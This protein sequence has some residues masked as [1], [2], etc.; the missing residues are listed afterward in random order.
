M[1]RLDAANA[2]LKELIAGPRQ[3]DLKAQRAE[4]KRL[5]YELKRIELSRDRNEQLLQRAAASRD[6]YEADLYA[7]E[8]TKANLDAASAELEALE[9]GTRVEKIEVQRAVVQEIEA[10][11]TSIDVDLNKSKIRAP[12]S[13]SIGER[14]VDEG[15]VVAVGQPIVSL[16]E[17]TRPELRVGVDTQTAALLK[18]GSSIPIVASNTEATGIIKAIRS[19]VAGRTRTVDVLI[20]LPNPGRSFRSGE[21][22]TARITQSVPA[23]GLWLPMAALT[24]GTR[25]LWSIF[26]CKPAD[27][28]HVLERRDVE[29]LHSETTRVFV[30]GAVAAGDRV[31]ISGINRLVPNLRVTVKEAAN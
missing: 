24:E 4:V 19:D 3:E 27:Q 31:V 26:V 23:V 2:L 8:S 20:S 7:A 28:H 10:E 14:L 11:I 6:R 12:F 5:G 21:L 17:V 1:A 30:R 13:G 16:L 25:G 29:V 9:N 22:A 18:P 15:N